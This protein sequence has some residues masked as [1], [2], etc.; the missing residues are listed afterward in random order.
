MKNDQLLKLFKK[1]LQNIDPDAQGVEDL[2]YEV[3]GDYM[4]YLMKKGH[5]PHHMMD[6]LE[7]DLREEVLEIYR[8]V[9]YGHMNLK[10]YKDAQKAKIKLPRSS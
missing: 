2:V 4:A 9:T 3:V 1:H 5:I 7:C 10:S 8:K 6:T